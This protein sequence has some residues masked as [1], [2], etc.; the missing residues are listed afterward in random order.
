MTAAA[1]VTAGVV[2]IQQNLPAILA[3]V[4]SVLIPFAVPFIASFLL[5]VTSLTKQYGPGSEVVPSD[6]T[7][8]V[9]PAV[10]VVDPVVDP[11]VD[12]VVDPAVTAAVPD[13]PTIGD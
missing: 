7:V 2:A 1:L 12:P 4:P 9:D 6:P 10:P 13:S 8:T 11:L 3:H 5:W